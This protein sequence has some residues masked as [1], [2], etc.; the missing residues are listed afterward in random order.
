MIRSENLIFDLVQSYSSTI[1]LDGPSL[2]DSPN[3]PAQKARTAT[4]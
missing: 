3:N 4:A 1:A 2:A